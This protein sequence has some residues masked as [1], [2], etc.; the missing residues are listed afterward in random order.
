MKNVQK[1]CYGWVEHLSEHGRISFSQILNTATKHGL[2]RFEVRD[3]RFKRLEVEIFAV[4]RGY[5]IFNLLD[6][7]TSS[8]RAKKMATDALSNFTRE[9]VVVLREQNFKILVA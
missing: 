1:Y 4:R 9:K 8:R 3:L 6:S 2:E 7:K 5:D